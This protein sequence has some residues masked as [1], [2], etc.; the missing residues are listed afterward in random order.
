MKKELKNS[1]E[2][3]REL[4]TTIAEARDYSQS[5]ATNDLFMTAEKIIGTMAF[6]ITPLLEFEHRFRE[7]KVK[8]I[9]EG[10]SAAAAEAKAQAGE[11]YKNYRQIKMTYDLADEAQKMIKKFSSQ[12]EGEYKRS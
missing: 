4:R 7:E 1:L 10:S 9:D 8:Y 12:L 3:A 2:Y 6:L 11:N 5:M